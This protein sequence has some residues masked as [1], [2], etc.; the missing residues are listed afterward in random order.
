MR[1][2]ESFLIFLVFIIICSAVLVG[3]PV[4]TDTSITSTTIGDGTVTI[5]GKLGT[6]LSVSRGGV[7]SRSIAGA[8]SHIAAI[9]VIAGSPDLGQVQTT[10]VAIDGSFNVELTPQ[11]NVSTLLLLV[12]DDAATLEEK[13]V[14]FASLN[15]TNGA[16]L[17]LFP[18]DMA[19][20]SMDFGT[21]NLADGMAVSSKSLESQQDAFT[22]EFDEL[23]QT[24]YH[25]NLFKH[26]KNQYVNTNHQTGEEYWERTLCYFTGDIADSENKWNS[27]SSW[28]HTPGFNMKIE[29]TSPQSYSYQDIVNRIVDI[30]MVPPQTFTLK[31]AYSP[32]IVISSESPLLASLAFQTNVVEASASP[33]LNEFPDWYGKTGYVFEFYGNEELIN[34]KWKMNLLRGGARTELALFDMQAASSFTADGSFI[35]YMPSIRIITDSNRRVSRIDIAWYAWNPFMCT[36]ERLTDLSAFMRLSNGFSFCISKMR[37]DAQG[38]NYNDVEYLP[39][40]LQMVPTRNWY[41]GSTVPQGG[42]DISWVNTLFIIA[43]VE[44][45]FT[46]YPTG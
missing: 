25:D 13:A 24:A 2:S 28:V 7:G 39:A 17:V 18:F 22:L 26:I 33:Y 30:E 43:G 29:I 5:S 31:G 44:Y 45:T 15:S 6:G 40:S 19:S 41:L 16:D 46:L 14:G 37:T 27:I 36:Y 35:Y 3:C 1:R 9:P 10:P 20:R 42:T 8:V 4:P 11:T 34:G 21:L 38:K 12:N 23:L 32:P